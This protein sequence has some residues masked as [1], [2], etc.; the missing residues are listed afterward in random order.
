MMEKIHIVAGS[1]PSSTFIFGFLSESEAAQFLM[2]ARLLV[3]SAPDDYVKN[4]L[5][6]IEWAVYATRTESADDA[7]QDLLQAMRKN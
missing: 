3:Y 2:R 4:Q 6:C 1:S 7:I 5:G